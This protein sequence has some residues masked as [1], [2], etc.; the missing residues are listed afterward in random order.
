MKL[1]IGIILVAAALIIVLT[2]SKGAANQSPSTKQHV[3][4][5]TIRA[6]I[7]A[8]GQLIDVRTPEEFSQGHIADATNLPVQ[9]I[10]SGSMPASDKDASVYVYCRSGSR[11]SQASSLLKDAG[12]TNVTDLGAMSAVQKLGGKVEL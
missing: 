10:K 2:M 5:E 12:Y 11:S 6:D 7:A 8:G 1:F 9:S 4:I 3:K